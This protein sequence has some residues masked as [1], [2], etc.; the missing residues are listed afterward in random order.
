M[1]YN[2]V[3]G[4]WAEDHISRFYNAGVS[5]GFI[6]ETFRPNAFTKRSELVVMVNRIIDRPNLEQE[7]PSFTDVSKEFWGYEAI[8]AATEGFVPL[9]Q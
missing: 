1:P 2:D 6:D 5:V 7:I 8:E 4:H 3:E 9:E